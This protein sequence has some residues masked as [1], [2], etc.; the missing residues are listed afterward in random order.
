MAAARAE[1]PSML[2]T[3]V[4][5]WSEIE[6]MTERREPLPAFAPGSAAALI[7]RALWAEVSA[8]LGGTF[9]RAPER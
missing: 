1:F 4:P 8:R 7:Y 3:E 2:A 9:A 5:Y 6:R